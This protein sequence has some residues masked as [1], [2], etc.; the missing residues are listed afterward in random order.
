[1]T[2]NDICLSK[3]VISKLVKAKF[4]DPL[5]SYSVFK[6][7]KKINQELEFFTNEVNKLKEKYYNEDDNSKINS[8]KENDFIIEAN[9]LLMIKIEKPPELNINIDDVLSAEFPEDKST[10]LNASDYG[11]L[12]DLLKE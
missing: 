10:W 11:I 3:D 1:M 6:Y 2:I 4:K 7:V 8:E 5:K 12:T 9:K